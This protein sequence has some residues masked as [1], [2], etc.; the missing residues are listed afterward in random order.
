MRN[1]TSKPKRT[2][3]G[4][5]DSRR[6]TPKVDT[7]GLYQRA[8]YDSFVK[9]DPRIQVKNPVMFVVWIGTIITALLT[10]NPSLFGSVSGENLRGF[11]GLITVILFFTLVFANFAEAV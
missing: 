10:I 1:S 6:H 11:N 4:P 9:L 7:K 8:I 5:R 3:Q 2:P